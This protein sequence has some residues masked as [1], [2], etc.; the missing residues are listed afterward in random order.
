M[1]HGAWW[2]LVEDRISKQPLLNYWC[3]CGQLYFPHS[4]DAFFTWPNA[5]GTSVAQQ[6]G[7]KEL[8]MIGST[9]SGTLLSGGAMASSSKRSRSA[10]SFSWSSCKE[11]PCSK[12]EWSL[13]M[14]QTEQAPKTRTQWAKQT[15]HSACVRSVLPCPTRI[16]NADC[17]HIR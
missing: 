15:V 11:R 7:R 1:H 14:N 9:L 2:G 16:T 10:A 4:K 8:G 3:K 13:C 6:D 12:P 17:A 5:L